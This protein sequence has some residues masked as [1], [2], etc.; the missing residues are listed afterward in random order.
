MRVTRGAAERGELKVCAL[1]VDVGARSFLKPLWGIATQPFRWLSR[2][3]GR[4]PLKM[5]RSWQPRT[6]RIEEANSCVKFVGMAF[7]FQKVW[8]RSAQICAVAGEQTVED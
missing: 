6:D 5:T 1:Q 4:Y 7:C 8:S 2:P 3:K